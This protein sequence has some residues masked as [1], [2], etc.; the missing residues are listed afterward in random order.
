MYTIVDSITGQVLFAKQDNE[1]LE[2]QIA[3]TELLTEPSREEDVWFF[4][5]ITRTFYKK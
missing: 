4:D 1:V 5:F 2:G 3:I